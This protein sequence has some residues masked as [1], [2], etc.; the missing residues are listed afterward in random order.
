MTEYEF[1]CRL[2]EM[3]FRTVNVVEKETKFQ[4]TARTCITKANTPG[5]CVTINGQDKIINWNFFNS[6]YQIYGCGKE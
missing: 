6:D 4:G 2:E 5:A 3:N 1:L